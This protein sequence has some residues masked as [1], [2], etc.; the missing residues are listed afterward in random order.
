MP[1]AA[2]ALLAA[3]VVTR[4]GGAASPR[5]KQITN[6]DSTATAYDSDV[7][8]AACDD[9]LAA[10]R[11]RTTSEPDMSNYSHVAICFKGALYF[12]ESYKGHNSGVVQAH[13][14]DFYTDL[15]KLAEKRYIAAATNSKMS[16]SQEKQ[17]VKPD[18]DSSRRLFGVAR[19]TGNSRIVTWEE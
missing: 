2:A 9:A 16:P 18:M 13:A 10:F 14:K 7:L 6:Y 4:L 15:E 11:V 5:L 1:S 19:R 17:G 3:E 8:L 12:C